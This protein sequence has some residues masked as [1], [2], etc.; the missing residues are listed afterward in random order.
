VVQEYFK[1][2][3]DLGG[4]TYIIEMKPALRKSDRKPLLEII[5]NEKPEYSFKKEF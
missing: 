1:E 5:K 4:E 2:T 3:F